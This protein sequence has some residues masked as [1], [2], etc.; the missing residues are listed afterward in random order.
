MSTM[1]IL[2][3]ALRFDI[4]YRDAFTCL[5][6][7]ARPGND[8]LEVDHLLPW[9]LGGN[10]A[11]PNLA[12][13]CVKCNRGKLDAVR[14]PH[15]MLASAEP[16]EHGWMTWKTWGCWSIR[17]ADYEMNVVC[18][19]GADDELFFPIG[20]AHQDWETYFRTALDL[21]A[22]WKFC[23]EEPPE[24]E[25]G[26]VKASDLAAFALRLE[27]KLRANPPPAVL[28]DRDHRRACLAFARS[29]VQRKPND[30]R[31]VPL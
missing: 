1:R 19:R 17:F 12:T 11:E 6:C 29:I 14:V 3:A 30:D 8:K 5:Y 31:P 28:D 16:D 25:L 18:D 2:P 15:S 4:L 26:F 10:D 13:S 9:S 27:R 20:R 21:D 24:D 7:G 22:M 23:G